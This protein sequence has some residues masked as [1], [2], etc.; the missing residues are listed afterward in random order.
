MI[1]KCI[2]CGLESDMIGILENAKDDEVYC[3]F[4]MHTQLEANAKL[5]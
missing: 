4:C 3:P 5:K 1:E 2:F